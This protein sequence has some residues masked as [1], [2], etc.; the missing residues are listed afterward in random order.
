MGGVYRVDDQLFPGRPTALKI[1]LHPLRNTVELFRAEFRTMASLRHPNV[2]RVYDFEQVAGQDAFFFTM[3]LLPGVPLDRFLA[4]P[5][6]EAETSDAGT[7]PPLP[8]APVIDAS[9]VRGPSAG[10]IVPW[11]D[12]LEL[13]V[14]V[15]RAL[16]YLHGRGVVHFDLK[17]GNIVVSSRGAQRHVVKVLDFG[18]AG[19][20]GARGLVMGTPHYLSPEIA[21]AK[22]GD[23]R[24]DLYSLG[25]MAYRL[26]TGETPF[27]T[28]QG[29]SV[30][31]KRKLTE[32]VRFT[33]AYAE[34]V[35][36][37][38]R[39]IVERLCSVDPAGRP[40]SAGDLLDEINRAGGLA[41]EIETR[42]ARE[43]YLFSS[44]FVGR[45]REM[46]DVN[47]SID[48][49]LKGDRHAGLF[50]AGRSGMGKSRLMREVRQAVQLR[51]VPFL[52]VDC[53]ERDLTESGPMANLVLQAARLAT[54]V[55]A[56]SLL[57][58]HAPEMVKLVPSLP[59]DAAVVPT[60][61]LPNA[62]AERRRVIEAIT[63]F[64][65]GLGRV[66]PYV[67][68]LN[69]LQWA[70]D[71]TADVASSLLAIR[72]GV[73][74]GL[75]VLPPRQLPRR[76]RPGP[77][78]RAPH[79]TGA[80]AP[81]AARRRALPAPRRR[82]RRPPQVHARPLRPAR[83]AR[84]AR[85]RV[86]RG[87]PVLRRGDPARPPR[88]GPARDGG[89]RGR[90]ARRGIAHRRGRVVPEARGARLARRAQPA[91]HPRRLGAARRHGRPAGGQRP[92]AAGGP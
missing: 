11:E 65:V 17:P 61:P 54:S 51:G 68:Y 69:D 3:E 32:R 55:G 87:P 30:L 21:S 56:Q 74:T 20:R 22:E 88:R 48:A 59:L 44:A 19:L 91:R 83:G 49:G 25:I 42:D 8:P 38:L 37:W 5:R 58:A 85:R 27:S 53:F 36:D 40:A 26:L 80:R 86:E 57:L 66:T 14:P 75:D 18:L 77:A 71:G 90:E 1:F 45:T 23:H 24:S 13:L 39:A 73:A 76:R 46:E 72:S 9:A 92:S 50:V 79:P 31:L 16:A 6:A 60:P 15:I 10:R 82:R 33:N 63:A 35:P 81:G 78:A 34:R 28:T 2:A 7:S 29:L 84:R 4:E 64:L 62:D 43:N 47:R 41:Y 67:A 52:E 70:R 12:A 89:R